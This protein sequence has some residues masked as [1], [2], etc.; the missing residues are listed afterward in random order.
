LPHPS[1]D[2][3]SQR[4]DWFIENFGKNITFIN[5]VVTE[6][7]RDPSQSQITETQFTVKGIWRY[8][9][10]AVSLGVYQTEA[11]EFDTDKII[12]LIREADYNQVK[13]AEFCLI[14]G[15]KFRVQ[16]I[17]SVPGFESPKRYYVIAEAT[18][19]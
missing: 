9:G 11:G 14:D 2:V 15:A 10:R 5:R 8:Q 4:L 6:S 17:A 16:K 13:E 3:L 19:R 18:R 7:K 1:L 12:I